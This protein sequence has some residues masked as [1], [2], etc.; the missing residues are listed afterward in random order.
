MFALVDANSFYCSAEQVFRPEWR[1]RPIIVLSNNDGMVVAANRQAKEAGIPKFQPY[2]KLKSLCEQKGVI[3]VSSNYELY[4]DLSAKMMQVIGRF[5]PEQHVYS[6]DESFLRFHRCH[7]LIKDYRQHALNIRSSVW[8]E[9]R[10]PVCVGMGKT[11]TLA[12]AANHTAKK[13][14][15]TNGIC[16]IDTEK[17]RVSVLKN[18]SVSDV[19]G[20]GRKLA[21]KL[22]VMKIH[23]AYDLSLYSPERARREFSIEMERTVRELNEVPCISWDLARADKKQIFSTRSMGQR[24]TDLD[25]LQQALSKHAGIAAY[26]ARQQGSLCKVLLCFA[27]SS[28]Y[29]DV[30]VSYKCLH[31]FPY[32]TDDTRIITK[33]V[34]SMAARLFKPGVRYYKIGVG[35]LE[36]QPAHQ[37]QI[38][39][40][41]PSPEDHHL[42]SVFDNLNNRYGTGTVF[43]AAQGTEHK[44]GMK[45]ELLTPQYTTKWH[46]LP[47]VK[48]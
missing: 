15:Q 43:L 17:L 6:I 18:M 14:R 13:H 42:M 39:W 35:F 45:R 44:W 24:I 23:T 33:A 48:C 30:P 47:L 2:F 20:I 41:N 22:K 11:I 28:P 27:S 4:S 9:C 16:V 12:K 7:G 31:H 29:D 37:Q 19:W 1:G 40:L 5:S 34:I 10:L 46:D 3:A 26:K 25:S 8:K 32:P 21:Q 38:D 36:L